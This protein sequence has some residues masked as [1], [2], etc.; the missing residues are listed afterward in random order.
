MLLSACVPEAH[1]QIGNAMARNKLIY[2]LADWALVVCSREWQRRHLGR[3]RENLK[4]T[5][6]PLLVRAGAEVS[7]GNKR[8][9]EAGSLPWDEEEVWHSQGDLRNLLRQAASQKE[10]SA[11]EVGECPEPEAVAQAGGRPDGILKTDA[12]PRRSQSF[13]GTAGLA[14]ILGPLAVQESPDCQS[15]YGRFGN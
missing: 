1:F 15:G 2:G 14:N 11:A 12:A 7:A 6:A 5:W 8:L 10:R 4:H 13:L 9:I 3:G